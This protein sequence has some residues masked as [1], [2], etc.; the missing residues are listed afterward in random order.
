MLFSGF[1]SA[2]AERNELVEANILA[3]A[4]RFHSVALRHHIADKRLAERADGVDHRGRNLGDLA[5][6]LHGAQA[7][8]HILEQVA[9]LQAARTHD[10]LVAFGVLEHR[11]EVAL[12]AVFERKGRLGV[13]KLDTVGRA[14]GHSLFVERLHEHDLAGDHVVVVVELLALFDLGG[15]QQRRARMEDQVEIVE[16]E[17]DAVINEVV[18]AED[19]INGLLDDLAL[20]VRDGNDA[21]LRLLAGDEH[22]AGGLNARGKQQRAGR[23][24]RNVRLAARLS[25]RFLKRKNAQA[26]NRVDD[27]DLAV[28]EVRRKLLRDGDVVDLRQDDEDHLAA[29]YGLSDVRRRKL[30]LAEAGEVGIAVNVDAAELVELRDRVI[31]NIENSGLIAL[32]GQPC[33]RRLAAVAGAD[34]GNRF[35]C[36]VLYLQMK[37]DSR[38]S[39]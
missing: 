13:R 25:Q 9:H 21:Q 1:R 39:R 15:I 36:H 32:I 20:A 6:D 34:N 12:I 10:A 8:R 18:L 5:E 16:R 22:I 30:D 7:E 4:E 26:G 28:N 19:R 33:G 17:L 29:L 38:I 2:V 37:D 23:S 14:D 3:Q 24:E 11:V 35:V 27:D 31:H